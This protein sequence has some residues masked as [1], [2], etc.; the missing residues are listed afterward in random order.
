MGLV[1]A[2]FFSAA[3]VNRR[4]FSMAMTAWSAKVVTNSICLSVKG[5][6]SFRRRS[7]DAEERALSEH[8]DVARIVRTSAC[9]FFASC[10]NSVLGVCQDVGNLNRAA[11][12]GGSPDDGSPPGA[13]RMSLEE[14]LISSAAAP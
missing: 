9:Q 11:L 10:T 7:E 1:T 6:T 14:A 13:G 12:E 5:R 8:G 3:P 2:R 4:T